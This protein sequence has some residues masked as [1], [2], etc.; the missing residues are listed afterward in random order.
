MDNDAKYFTGSIPDFTADRLREPPL[1]DV[2]RAEALRCVALGQR[3]AGGVRV[4]A[5]ALARMPGVSPSDRRLAAAAALAGLA[6]V[7]TL[8]AA[9]ALVSGARAPAPIDSAHADASVSEPYQQ[10]WVLRASD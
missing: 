6:A 3:A 1:T 2:E 7:V 4:A 5:D 9:L 10:D 8:I